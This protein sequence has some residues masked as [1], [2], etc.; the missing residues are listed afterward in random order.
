MPAVGQRGENLGD[1][2]RR[3][4]LLDQVLATIGSNRL[5]AFLMEESD[6]VAAYKAGKW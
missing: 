6:R 3:A 2:D 1:A 5:L 4:P